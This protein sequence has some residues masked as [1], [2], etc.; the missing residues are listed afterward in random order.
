MAKNHEIALNA[1]TDYRNRISAHMAEFSTADRKIAEYLLQLDPVQKNFDLSISTFSEMTDVSVSSVIRFCK[2]LGYNG[3]AE[4]KF[5]I[6]QEAYSQ[7]INDLSIRSED[8]IMEIKRKTVQFAYMNMSQTMDCLDDIQLSKAIQA[9]KCA[10][11]VYFCGVGS[12]SGVARLAANQFMLIGIRSVAQSD[13]LLNLRSASFMESNDV[14][15]VISYDGYAKQSADALML[16]KEAGATTILITQA[17]D[18]LSG[19]YA[20]VILQNAARNA[21]NALNITTSSMCQL[22][23]LQLLMVGVWLT[24]EKTFL[25][26][27]QWQRSV[28]E[29]V[30]YDRQQKEV[31]K[32]RI[33]SKK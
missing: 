15:V 31:S 12:A 10:D 17:K 18:S 32:N 11:L 13:I 23:I 6:Q 5:R 2:L 24:D 26:A 1:E 30:R 33:I 8:N 20:D 19:Q 16:A 25:E 3:F 7:N 9:I 21:I 27:T 28:S 14:M 29:M 4:L 22:A